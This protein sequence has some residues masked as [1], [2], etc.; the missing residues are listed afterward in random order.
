MKKDRARPKSSLRAEF[1]QKKD[2]LSFDHTHTYGAHIDQHIQAEA[3]VTVGE[4]ETLSGLGQAVWRMRGLKT[5][6]QTL[7]FVMNQKTK[8]LVSN[9]RHPT[10]NDILA[11][12][13]ENEA[14]MQGEENYLSDMQKAANVIRRSVLDK[15]IFAPDVD[16]ML[17]YFDEFE[18][19]LTT[20][21]EEDPFVL[22]GSLEKEL[23]PAEALDA[24]KQGQFALIAK[25]SLF[26]ATEKKKIE[27][28]LHLIGDGPYHST[29][30][31]YRDA[32]GCIQDP[33]LNLNQEQTVEQDQNREVEQEVNRENDIHREV[34]AE[35][36]TEKDPSYPKITEKVMTW[37]DRVDYFK[38]LTWLNP[39]DPTKEPYNGTVSIFPLQRVLEES[40][41]PEL[42]EIADAFAGNFF[43]TNNFLGIVPGYFNNSLAVANSIRQKPVSDI[44]VVQ[45]EF[46]RPMMIALSQDEAA[47]WRKKMQQDRLREPYASSHRIGLLNLGLCKIV[48]TGKNAF[49]ERQLFKAPNFIHDLARWKF[50]K[51]D[52]VYT[53]WKRP[54]S[55]FNPSA[56]PTSDALQRELKAWIIK[57]GAKEMKK[58][59]EKIYANHAM[60]KFQGSDLEFVF[61][62]IAEDETIQP[63]RPRSAASKKKIERQKSRNAP[64]GIM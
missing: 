3:V 6:K 59:F 62:E 1:L 53:E 8:A 29:V 52:T 51:G 34:F 41:S 10:I 32:K 19:V 15:M 11:F 46:E 24:F 60:N 12:A 38:S 64:I 14:K 17:K 37:D 45:S 9:D 13:T 61:L 55:I 5:G 36:T 2:S 27:E 48:C 4:V 56:W 28:E 26:S 40:F 23:T 30:T 20:V 43:C 58:A 49:D 47:M 21:T 44:L 50:Y 33:L 16:T 42:E 57:Y 31:V 35:L 25:T 54:A 22:Y 7:Q 18:H 39:I 63:P